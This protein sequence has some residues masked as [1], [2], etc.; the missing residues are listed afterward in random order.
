MTIAPFRAALAACALACLVSPA[1]AQQL[2]SEGAY[3]RQD[4]IEELERLLQQATDEND[5]LQYQLQQSQAE[6]RRLQTMVGDLAAVR[7]ARDEI[8]QE[9][10][11]AAPPPP[12]RGQQASRESPI[13][14]GSLG[15]LPA[16]DLPGDAGETF[17][18]ARQYLLNNQIRA[19]EEA[20]EDFIARFGNDPNAPEARYWFA[21]TLLARDAHTEAAS[22]FIDYLRRYPRGRRAPDAMVRLGIALKGAGRTQQACA[23]FADFRR[24]YPNAPQ[25]LRDLATRE[26]RGARCA[27]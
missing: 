12:A 25:A 19:A 1:A 27:A 17:Q 3:A 21:F 2:P 14:Q 7:D 9:N 26:A 8:E 5:R 6:V 20:F 15:E 24:T 22:G 13:Q 10:A 4:R 23:A 18:R 16:E 11:P